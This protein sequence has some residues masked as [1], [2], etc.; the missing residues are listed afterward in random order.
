MDDF[1]QFKQTF[2]TESFELL[3]EMEEKLLTLD[4]A[5]CDS[6]D[7]N[8]IFRCIHS[9]KGGAGAFSLTQLVEFTHVLE[10]LLDKMREGEIQP[11][12]DIMDHLLQSVDVVKSFV[13]AAQAGQELPEEHGAE[14][15][16]QLEEVLG[17]QPAMSVESKAV[18][19]G[20]DGGEISIY[21]IKFKPYPELFESGNEPLYLFRE[22]RS[23]GE[24]TVHPIKDKLPSFAKLNPEHC[25][26]SWESELITNHSEDRIREVFEF[27]E[28]ECDLD[29]ALVGGVELQVKE[30]SAQAKTDTIIADDINVAPDAKDAATKNVA[31]GS[32]RVDIAKVDQLVNMVGELVITQS[33]L[34]NH[35]KELP[36]EVHKDLHQGIAE[37]TRHTRELQ[38]SVMA[39]R[40]QPVKSVFARMPRIVRDISRKLDKKIRIEM[41]G[42]NTEIDKTMIEQ[43]SDPLTHMIRNSLD[44]GIEAPAE[45]RAAG[46]PEEGVIKL[47]ADNSGGRINIEIEDDG[48]GINRE[49]VLQLAQEKGLVPLDAALT[50]EEIDN[51]IFMPGFSTADEIT[52]VSGRGVGMDVVKQNIE[53]LGGN[54]DVFN[55]PS[56]GS[57]IIISLP[58]TLA[59]L[60]G[61]I[62]GVGEEKY[63]IP[64]N[65]IIESLCP[66]A[67]ELA[68]ITTGNDVINVRGD[69]IPVIYLDHI[70]DIAGSKKISDRRLLVLLESGRHRFGVVVDE[71][72]G[73][74]QV[75]IKSIEEN[76]DPVPGVSGA[77]ILGDGNVSLILDVAKL[78]AMTAKDRHVRVAA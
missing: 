49:K 34:V 45:R 59:I 43:L 28:D 65:N 73:Q 48:A 69:F 22:L 14:L 36:V 72:I 31:V 74:Q 68:N 17:A 19:S 44:H 58:L 5:A 12:Q 1:E 56:Q 23:L 7:I 47:S 46:K 6:E 51:L 67:E 66:D 76:S 60:D 53:G 11:N 18:V 30:I 55:T 38:E 24:L 8:A 21:S 10:T 27:V 71:I 37:L 70:F 3:G 64:I 25:Y 2:I 4:E 29:I 33:M 42:E 15:K 20:Q 16:A 63:I 39:V 35:T 9:I 52:D 54:I 57:K 40:M 50:E 62:V 32:M 41:L 13:V 77:T 61:M 78:Q 26:L 75:V